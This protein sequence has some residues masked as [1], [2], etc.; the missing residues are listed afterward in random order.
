MYDLTEFQKYLKDDRKRPATI[1]SYIRRVKMFLDKIQP[2]PSKFCK[3][4]ILNWKSFCSEYHNNSLTPMYGAI[5]KFIEF[6][7]DSEIIDDGIESIARRKL[8]APKLKYD[9]ENIE[10][11]VIKPV[12]FNKIFELSKKKNYMHF[13]LFKTMFWIMARR[14]EVLG[15][16]IDDID[17]RNMKV[18]FREEIAKGGKRATVNISK[19]C[20]DILDYYIKNIR[21]KPKKE[22]F[23]DI[24]FL[25]DGQ[26]LSR[27]KMFEI[28]KTYAEE[29]DIELTPHMWRHTGITEYAKVEKDVKLVQK[30]A[31]HE[32]VNITMRYINYAKGTYEK[33][34]H[35]KFAKCNSNIDEPVVNTKKSEP[36]EEDISKAELLQM[37]KELKQEN[38]ELKKLKK[39]VAN[40]NRRNLTV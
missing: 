26:P 28:N 25:R 24:L 23:S 37:I 16:K 10:R 8:K 4:D 11:L 9:E 39:E 3:D 15:L 38:R 40:W 19:E 32:D 6:L 30:Q 36:L 1:D 14:C 5:K 34:Y 35:E 22:K 21:G 20:L 13:A 18:T 31:R 33:S 2:D 27:T 29:L 12:D 17:T 7:A